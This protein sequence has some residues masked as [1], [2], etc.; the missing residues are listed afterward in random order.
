MTSQLRRRLGADEGEL[1]IVLALFGATVIPAAIIN[2]EFFDT[3]A[4][5]IVLFGGAILTSLGLWTKLARPC[6]RAARATL[7]VPGRMDAL[8]A[9]MDTV[10][11][12]SRAT[13]AKVDALTDRLDEQRP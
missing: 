6:I 2:H 8:G 11:E 3:A 4:A 13:G 7:A 9:R 10:E 5:S 1:S 12:V